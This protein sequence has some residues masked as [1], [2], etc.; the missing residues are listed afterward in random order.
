M[1][2]LCLSVALLMLCLF[3]A[4]LTV[5]AAYNPFGG[6]CNNPSN[7]TSAACTGQTTSDPLTGPGG[8]LANIT[9]IIAF[10]AG[11]AAIIVVV[12]GGLRYIT[13]GGDSNKAA[14]ARKT[15]T[16]ALIG[17]VIIVLGRALI[18]F[19]VGRLK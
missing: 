12:V 5:S 19:V 16:N 7:A 3:A 1:R 13:A 4:P 11:A 8:K 6:V 10:V 2:R 17:I 18:E 9:N 15:V 14:E